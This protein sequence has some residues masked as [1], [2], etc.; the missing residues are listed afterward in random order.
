MVQLRRRK[1]NL[2][3][4]RRRNLPVQQKP[5]LDSSQKK[6]KV[7][8]SARKKS[9]KELFVSLPAEEEEDNVEENSVKLSVGNVAAGGS[10]TWRYGSGLNRPVWNGFRCRSLL[11]RAWRPV[12]DTISE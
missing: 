11:R 8:D 4:R 1:T 12:L 7:K 10:G 6:D 5:L 2:R 9:L 3:S